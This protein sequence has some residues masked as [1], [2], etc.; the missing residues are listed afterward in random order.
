MRE[1]I[2]Q[3]R[4]KLT[5]ARRC[6]A[7]F[8]L[9]TDKR[10]QMNWH[11]ALLCEYLDRFVAKEITRLM[12]FMPPRYG[13]SE[14]V[15]RKLPAFI[16]GK[17]PDANIIATSHTADLAQQMNR[18]VQRIIDDEKYNEVFPNTNLSGKSNRSITLKGN[19]L[20]NSDVFEIIGHRQ[21]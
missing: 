12:V 20:R 9:Y 11:H 2:D 13:K 8:A 21:P 6:L 19:Y 10:Y 15:S 4:I 7:D 17:N 18:D 5:L 14:L 3:E 1:R 16:F